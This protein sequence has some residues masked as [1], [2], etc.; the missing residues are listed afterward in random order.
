MGLNFGDYVQVHIPRQRT[1][2]NEPRRVGAIAL[3]PKE[4]GQNS[5]VFMSLLT[6]RKIHGYIWDIIPLSNEVIERVEEIGLREGQPIVATNFKYEW[7]DGTIIG[8]PDED[9]GEDEVIDV[10]PR[11]L[12]EPAIFEEVVDGAEEEEENNN[13]EGE[14][15]AGDE[16]STHSEES[17]NTGA[18]L[19]ENVGN[20]QVNANEDDVVNDDMEE[21]D[22][23]DQAMQEDAEAVANDIPCDDVINEVQT[24]RE[25][26]VDV[27][28]A[29]TEEQPPTQLK[30]S[31]RLQAKDSLNYKTYATK[32]ID[33]YNSKVMRDVQHKQML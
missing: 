2:N 30:R 31:S 1:N 20:Y 7:A 18:D 4:N 17:A 33:Q 25:Q 32:G 3:Y 5:W 29:Q 8:D 26:P 24:D 13:P 27:E 22:Q 6:G 9:E 15:A 14:N 21:E 11:I 10:N 16:E 12:P 23:D 19:T 28:T